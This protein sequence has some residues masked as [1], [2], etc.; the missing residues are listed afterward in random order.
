LEPTA[1]SVVKKLSNKKFEIVDIEVNDVVYSS[2]ESGVITYVTEDGLTY[3]QIITVEEQERYL[4]RFNFR[5]VERGYIVNMERVLGFDPERHVL[6]FNR[7]L[8]SKDPVAPV[9]KPYQTALRQDG[10]LTSLIT[11]HSG[12]SIMI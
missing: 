4:E 2:I 5:R 10:I 3:Y 8:N 6:Y 1:I 9:S 12:L 7:P 11:K